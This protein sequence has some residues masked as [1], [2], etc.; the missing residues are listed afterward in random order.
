MK[1]SDKIIFGGDYNPE[2]WRETPE[3]WDEDMRLM[4]LARWNEAT[5]GVFSFAELEPEEGVFDFSVTDAIFEKA[6]KNGVKIILSTPSGAMPRWMAEK[7]PEILRT[8]EDRRKAVYGR[9]ENHCY[10]SPV[11]R[12]KVAE[13]DRK[14]SE[15]YGRHP[16]LLAWHISNEFNGECHCPLCR[17]AFCAFLEKKYGTV[18]RLNAEWWTRFWSHRA[19]SFSEIEPPSSIGETCVHGLTLDWKR[20]VTAQTADFA[21]VEIEAVRA[22]SDRPV[23]TNL[24]GFYTGLDYRELS[25][26]F[27]FISWD[28]YPDW[29]KPEGDEGTAAWIALTHDL[30][31]SMKRENFL[32][33]ESTPSHTNWKDINK[34]YRPGM[35]RLASLQALA[36]GSESVQYFQWRKSRG[37]SEKMHGAVVDHYGREDTRVFS[38]VAALGEELERLSP[39]VGSTLRPRVA[40]IYDWDNVWALQDL[41]GMQKKNKQVASALLRQYL[42]FWRAGISCDIIGRRESFEGYSL[43]VA[44]MTYL[45]E[46]ETAKRLAGF[47]REGGTLVATYALAQTNENDL[48]HL[49]G[50]PGAGLCE[51]FGLRAE[52]LDTLYPEERVEISALGGSYRAKDYCE[53]LK[54]HADT[55]ILGEYR[56]EFYAGTPCLTAHAYG[57][58]KAYYIAFRDADGAFSGAFYRRVMRELGLESPLP[59]IPDG[60][61]VQ[62]RENEKGEK[63]FFLLNFSR[64]EKRLSLGEGFTLLRTGEPLAEAVLPPYG[65]EVLRK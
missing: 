13:I 45:C 32:L 55:E 29:G 27:D 34:L 22:F 57:K 7:Y 58:G 38:E 31:R 6:E 53:V 3:I 4:R 5:V 36:H 59:E 30:M 51:V 10:T 26:P 63:F 11:Y 54:P 49:G 24:M 41:Q 19:N 25:R 39:L 28:N 52:E 40:M 46:E 2:Q 60:V 8:L 65:A 61:S 35:M 23:T 21:R 64:N 12:E 16:A 9:R 20:F 62:V 56:G 47:V 15:R 43:L 50:F 17:E 1:L 42:P 48:C 37:S 44:P 14:L 18:D 33:M